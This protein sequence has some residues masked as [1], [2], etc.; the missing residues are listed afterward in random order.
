MHFYDC[1]YHQ[2]ATR[3]EDVCEALAEHLCADVIFIIWNMVK[4]SEERV[5]AEMEEGWPRWRHR[6]DM[7]NG[8]FKCIRRGF[9]KG[10][11]KSQ[12]VYE[13]IHYESWLEVQLFDAA[14]NDS[15][16]VKVF[17]RAGKALFAMYPKLYEAAVEYALNL[18]P[19]YAYN[20]SVLNLV[21]YELVCDNIAAF[22]VMAIENRDRYEELFI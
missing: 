2:P 6:M 1:L 3:Y 10:R 11:L 7:V 5:R 20:S 21:R 14:D 8:A 22:T 12:P 19:H 4:V 16:D 17:A 9:V 18:V 13:Y 15:S